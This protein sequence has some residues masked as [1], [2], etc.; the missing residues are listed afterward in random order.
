MA[1]LIRAKISEPSGHTADLNVQVSC[2]SHIKSPKTIN[3]SSTEEIL[4]NWKNVKQNYVEIYIL[5]DLA[6]PTVP[7][8]NTTVVY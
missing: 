6:P 4:K 5:C 7:E 3:A 8:C 2:F 1:Q